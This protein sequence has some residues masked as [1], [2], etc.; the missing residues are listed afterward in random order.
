[1]GSANRNQI[2]RVAPRRLKTLPAAAF[3]VVLALTSSFADNKASATNSSTPPEEL[4]GA[5]KNV[6]RTLGFQ[7][8]ANFLTN[9][10]SITAYYRCYYT[11]KLELPESY[12]GLQLEDGTKDGCAVNPEKYDVFF[13]PI[14]AVAN[15]KSPVTGSLAKSSLERLLVVVPH[16]DFH[17]NQDLQKARATL[18]EAAST[19]VGFLTA[20]QVAREQ[21]GGN[22]EAYQ[23]LSKEAG[24]F[25]E[26]AEIV[27]RYHVKLSHLYAQVR[28]GEITKQDAL[29]L[30]ASLFL[31][32][33]SDCKAISPDPKSFNKC[34]SAHNN[35]GLAF[36][37][38]YTQFY[39]VM[40]SLYLAQ[41]QDVKATIS[42][43][44]Q[45]LAEGSAVEVVQHLRDLSKDVHSPA[46]P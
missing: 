46:S 16:E 34:P 20:S 2:N 25:L 30:K 27:N 40:Y 41:G 19:L 22:S 10:D 43:L 5:V 37:R 6:E 26:K 42:T 35:A 23:H 32:L 1:L 8:T 29:G 15:G 39:P 11:G 33:Q 36:D 4:I 28:A 24:L 18:N 7:P 21:F 13:Y 45:A 9:S 12:E 38:T 14:E 44:R 17:Q 31:E 3:L